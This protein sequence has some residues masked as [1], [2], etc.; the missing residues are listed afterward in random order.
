MEKERPV[1]TAEWVYYVNEE[2]KARWKCSAC[3]KIVRRLPYD[4]HYCSNCG[5]KMESETAKGVY[6]L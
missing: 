3:G 2:H 5:A 1:L 6:C 4:K